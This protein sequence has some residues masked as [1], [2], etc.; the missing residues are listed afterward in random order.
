MNYC[1]SFI[2]ITLT[3]LILDINKIASS[4]TSTQESVIWSMH[5]E[6]ELKSAQEIP[7]LNGF[8]EMIKLTEE[9]KLWKFPIDNEQGIEEFEDA[10]TP[11]HEHIFLD[12]HLERF[13]DIEPIQ[14]FMTLAING[15]SKNGFISLKEKLEIIDW[16]HDYFSG[17]LDLINE[18]LS[19]EQKER[20][21]KEALRKGVTS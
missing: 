12:H 16:Y 4:T 13:P 1:F 3:I 15:L 14:Q 6:E 19:A 20:E 11:F 21:F 7:H 10:Q 2:K 5:Q 8:E 18:A 9:G 17:K